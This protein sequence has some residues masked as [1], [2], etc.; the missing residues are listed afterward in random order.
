[1]VCYVLLQDNAEYL[2]AGNRLKELFDGEMKSVFN[3]S[4]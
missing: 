1:M 4:E 3:I 2:A